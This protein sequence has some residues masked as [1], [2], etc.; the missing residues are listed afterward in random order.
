MDECNKI[1]HQQQQQYVQNRQTIMKKE[2]K[3]ENRLKSK[4][5]KFNLLIFLI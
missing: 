3:N 5:S 4:L 2:K 1:E